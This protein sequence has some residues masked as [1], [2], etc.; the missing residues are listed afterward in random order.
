M[1]ARALSL[2]VCC[3]FLA[4]AAAERKDGR[5]GSGDLI[6]CTLMEVLQ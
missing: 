5:I 2:S 1:K 6:G 4:E 3:L